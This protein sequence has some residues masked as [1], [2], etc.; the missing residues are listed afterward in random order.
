M[1]LTRFDSLFM[2]LLL[3][4]LLMVFCCVM[5][6]GTFVIVER[7]NVQMPY[8]AESWA[9]VFAAAVEMPPSAVAVTT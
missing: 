1:I 4:Q 2:R 5:I 3:T 8:F 9:P 7:N 6:F